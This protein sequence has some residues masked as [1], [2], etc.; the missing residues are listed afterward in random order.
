LSHEIPSYGVGYTRS[1]RRL[2]TLLELELDHEYVEERKLIRSDKLRAMQPQGELPVA[3]IDGDALYESAAIRSNFCDLAPER[4]LLAAAGTR[5]R[6]FHMQWT[7]FALTEIERYQLPKRWSGKPRDRISRNISVTR[8][9]RLSVGTVSR[10]H[11][12]EGGHQ[13]ATD[14]VNFTGSDL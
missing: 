3:L 5:E 12:A 4:G 10:H 13:L 14:A 9:N 11:A 8:N 7:S 6:G 1:S 2:W